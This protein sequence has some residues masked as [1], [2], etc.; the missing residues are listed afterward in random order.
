MLF[1]L[2]VLTTIHAPLCSYMDSVD[3]VAGVCVFAVA[4]TQQVSAFDIPLHGYS[5]QNV[6]FLYWYLIH[7]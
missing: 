3:R 7:H 5:V 4:L 6:E 1:E 2:Q